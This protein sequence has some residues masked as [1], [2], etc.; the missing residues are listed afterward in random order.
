MLFDSYRQLLCNAI[1]VNKNQ[2][3]IPEKFDKPID[4]NTNNY[5]KVLS[6]KIAD[7]LRSISC[8]LSANSYI[9]PYME[10]M[11]S[12]T[13]NNIT[14]S[15]TKLTVEQIKQITVKFVNKT[16]RDVWNSK[17]DEVETMITSILNGDDELNNYLK[18]IKDQL[19]LYYVPTLED[20]L[21]LK[22]CLK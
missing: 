21:L 20:E 11:R 3:P 19:E 13:D 22:S 17:K 18:N 12:Y 1:K 6:N 9:V 4:D 14:S 8:K 10:Y 15:S 2:F 5:L 7:Q 16:V